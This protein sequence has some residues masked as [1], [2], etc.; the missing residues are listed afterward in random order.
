METSIIVYLGGE[1]TNK[2]I[3]EHNKNLDLYEEN[4]FVNCGGSFVKKIIL[5]HICNLNLIILKFEQI[6]LTSYFST[7]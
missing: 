3:G 4:S 6:I 1:Y 5:L 2:S 7:I